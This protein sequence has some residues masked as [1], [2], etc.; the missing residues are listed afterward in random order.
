VD[1]YAAMEH[2]KKMPEIDGQRI[3]YAGWSA[4]G[5]TAAMLA[6]GHHAPWG[7]NP[8]KFRA[9]VSHYASC[10]FQ[11]GPNT[12]RWRLLAPI[13]DTPILMLMAQHDAE[14]K[15]EDCFPQL[16]EMKAAGQ[17]VAWHVYPNGHHAWDQPGVRYTHVNGFGQST[18]YAHDAE[19]TKDATRRMLA[20]FEQHR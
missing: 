12:R 9:L 15:P 1:A 5:M 3:Y 11:H 10:V 14:L 4:G 16:D 13:I 8:P 6:A 19:I 2:L 20:F 7:G 17:P 18:V